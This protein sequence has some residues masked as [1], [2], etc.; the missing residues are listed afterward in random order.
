MLNV[1]FGLW[2]CLRLPAYTSSCCWEP[3]NSRG[4]YQTLG[5]KT[6]NQ[7]YIIKTTLV[8]TDL[9]AL[10]Y[11][12]NTY[13]NILYNNNTLFLLYVCSDKTSKWPTVTTPK[14]YNA[15]PS[16]AHQ[17]R[18]IMRNTPLCPSLWNI[19]MENLM[20][21][22]FTGIPTL[23]AGTRQFQL[24]CLVAE[25]GFYLVLRYLTGRILSQEALLAR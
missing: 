15:L 11:A 21:C 16:L 9:S 20:S 14:Y 12:N 8:I 3:G 24:Y 1:M 4:Y 2:T 10:C 22:Y 7:D 23:Q 19:K 13:Y 17:L 25:I 6:Y 5:I 18:H